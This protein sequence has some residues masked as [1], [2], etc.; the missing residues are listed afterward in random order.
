M[1]KRNLKEEN[2]SNVGIIDALQRL[3]AAQEKGEIDLGEE[4]L[5]KIKDKLESQKQK[6]SESLTEETLDKKLDKLKEDITSKID[7]KLNELNGFKKITQ[8]YVK[9][10]GQTIVLNMKGEDRYKAKKR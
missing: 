6:K 2:N 3:L 9:V 8:T 4:V 1:N 5:G 7:E 10:D